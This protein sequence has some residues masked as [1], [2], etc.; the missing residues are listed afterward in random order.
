MKLRYL[1]PLL[2]LSILGAA[3]ILHFK[4]PPETEL[5]PAGK[6]GTV[7][8]WPARAVVL[9]GAERF[10]DPFG[11]ALDRQGN[12]YIADDNRIRKLSPQGVATTFAEG[13]DTPSG[14][15]V[16]QA[17]NL[18][19]ADTGGNTIRKVTPE[20]VVTTLAGDGTA[21]YRDG[22]AGRARFNGPVGVAVDKA[23]TVFVADT[24][25]DR[26]RA[27]SPSGQVTTFAEG[28]D[29]P[30]ALLVD[31][32]GNLVVADTKHDAIRVIDGAGQVSTMP[33]ALPISLALTP[34]G[35][36][37]VGSLAHG[38][39]FQISPGG[40]IRGLTG[41]DID[42]P[43]GDNEALRVVEPNGLAVAADGSL[44]VA[45]SPVHGLRKIVPRTDGDIAIERPVLDETPPATVSWPVNPKLGFHE[46]V[47]T[48]GEVRGNDHGDSRDHFHAGLDVQANM[49]TPVFAIT[50]GKVRETLP[51][52]GYETLGEGLSIDA[53]SYIHM[54][55]GRLADGSPIDPARFPLF[56]DD[57]GRTR[58]RVKRGT[59]FAAGDMLGTVN[60]M[61]H[62]HLEFSPDGG[63]HNALALPFPGFQDRIAPRIESIQLVDR[64]GKALTAKQNGRLLVPS[65][66]GD[67]G[68]VVGAYDQIDGNAARRRI[69][70]YQAGYQIL[71][72]SGQPVP[73]FER[74]LVTIEFNR[75]PP[76][77]EAVKIAYAEGSG[78]TVHGS[79]ATRFLYA[80]TNIVRDGRAE[81]GSWHAADLPRGDYLV[82]IF[83][84]DR[85]GNVAT[86]GRDLPVTL[87]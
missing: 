81:T 45:D 11:L 35:F 7:F 72:A 82:R 19:V 59:R 87:N 2:S 8:G 79:T 4:S 85:A 83:A 37:Y 29:T 63:A 15:A 24:Y 14:L 27:I 53:V 44:L 67:I 71:S 46:V 69:G 33:L 55:V 3:A 38:R 51:S 10:A 49:G 75:L 80:V 61:Y 84:A 6:P 68:I 74:P 34:D 21:G 64:E 30:S 17:G 28:F 39:I 32:K 60:R 62:V 23:G 48:M 65:S 86:T 9:A 13:F 78:E 18:F 42:I 58:I 56:K 73:G 54:R 43:R 5:R 52:W 20:G 47:G 57:G 26:I 40:E 41:L 31:L 77:R 66:A 70:L 76:D 36:L 22:P 16:D 1:I 50:P 25:N 12:L